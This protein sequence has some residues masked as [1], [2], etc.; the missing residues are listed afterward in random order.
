MYD[1]IVDCDKTSQSSDPG[2][3]LAFIELESKHNNNYTERGYTPWDMWFRKS[4]PAPNFAGMVFKTVCAAMLSWTCRT[5]L[6]GEV[7]HKKLSNVNLAEMV[8]ET[9]CGEMLSRTAYGK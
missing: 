6:V 5:N 7:V 3:E 8:A 4:F 9:V 1:F 2:I